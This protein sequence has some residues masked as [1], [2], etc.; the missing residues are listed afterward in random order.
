M[1]FMNKI[2]ILV[3]STAYVSEELKENK[4]LKIVYLSVN[5]EN[6]T[7]RELIDITLEEYKKYL[8]SDN[9]TFPTTSQPAIGEI[10]TALENLKEEGYNDVICI[11]LSSGISGTYSSYSVA[12]LMVSD[13]NV[14]PFDS[15]ASCHV[16]GF[17]VAK[18]IDLIN[19]GKSPIEI[20]NILEN[21]KLLTEIYIIVDDL[22][23]LQ[24]GGRLSGGQALVG[25]LLQV[26]PILHFNN[27]VIVPYQKIR[28]YKK[29]I[30]RVLELF[31]DFYNLNNDENGKINVCVIDTG[32]EEK[33]VEIVDY[34]KNKYPDIKIITGE[35]GPV[36][37]THLGLG[38]VALGWTKL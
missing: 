28:T 22:N 8:L 31:D 30:L 32:A 29:A 6:S 19:E 23:H 14:Y 7:K 25:S 27:K 1:C 34:L 12:S 21:I 2:A 15:E 33:V 35:I 20:I 26:K 16:E 37:A 3:D 18:T 10:V 5:V 36:I 9:K 38:A 24:R 17:Y 11:S 13:V 4:N